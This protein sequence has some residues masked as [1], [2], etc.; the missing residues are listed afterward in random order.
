MLGVL[1][2]EVEGAVRAG[3]AKSAVHRVEADGVDGVDV[4]D[5]ALRWGGLTV[6]FE[7]EIGGRVFLF[8]VLDGAAALDA[9]DCEAGG[10]TEAGDD[11]G[12][13]F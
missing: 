10:V 8:D 7:A 9:A 13:P 3:G 11:A 2:P 1:V 6:A 5:V 4:G 12:L